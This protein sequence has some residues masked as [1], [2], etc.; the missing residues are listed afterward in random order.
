MRSMPLVYNFH[1]LCAITISM[2]VTCTVWFR[3][4]RTS[5][6]EWI[7]PVLPLLRMPPCRVASSAG[8]ARPS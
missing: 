6:S 4:A 5:V 8:V 7:F 1:S 3:G 2:G